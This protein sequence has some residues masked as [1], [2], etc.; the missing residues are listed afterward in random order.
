[1]S[2][3]KIKLLLIPT[4]F[5]C[6]GTVG[7]ATLQR[8]VDP[9]VK[10]FP[11]RS[12][13]AMLGSEFASYA[14]S[15]SAQDREEAIYHQLIQGNIPNFLRRSVSI[16]MRGASSLH[17]NRPIQVTLWLMPDYL[18]IGSDN[19][20]V[21]IP[22]TPYMAQRVAEQFDYALPTKKVVDAIYHQASIKLQPRPLPADDHMTSMHQFIHHQEL[23][24]AQLSKKI[25]GAL[26]AGHKKDVVITPLL[27]KNENR[28]AIYGWHRKEGAPIQ[29]LSLVHEADYADYS[30]G[31][32]LIRKYVE[33]NGELKS[34]D[35]VL[36]NPELCELLS[37]E[38]LVSQNYL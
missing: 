7:N 27:E 17:P 16:Q 21:R 10:S 38:G 35:E 14:Q 8:R 31:I 37:D 4:L 28:V 25:P 30:H 5:L 18:A 19:D 15:L 29:K 6:L 23:I 32:R 36:T 1:M 9:L 3:Y 12:P 13:S 33:I 20:F 2:F 11:A 24:E 26:V 34:L 22:M